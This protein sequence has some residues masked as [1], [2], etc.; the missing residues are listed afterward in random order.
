[1]K[2][3]HNWDHG[4]GDICKKCRRVHKDTRKLKGIQRSEETKKKISISHKGFKCTQK[5]KQK[6]SFARK[7]WLSNHKNS[8]KG[9]I[10]SEETKR[11]ISKGL[12][13]SHKENPRQV[14]QETKQKMSKIRK[15][16][17]KTHKNPMKGKHHT[18]E[19]KKKISETK[20]KKSYK[21]TEEAKYKISKA[22][23]GKKRSLEMRKKESVGMKKVWQN[24]ERRILTSSHNH[25]N[26]MGGISKKS[27]YSSYFRYIRYLIK[28]RDNFQCQLC[29]VGEEK[30][31]YEL[32]V[33]HIDFNKKNNSEDNLLTLCRSCNSKVNLNRERW[34]KNLKLH[35]NI[36]VSNQIF[37]SISVEVKM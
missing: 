14:S 2:K 21:H 34:T 6:M 25:W 22:R 20:R 13:K 5:T 3:G 19:T 9:R 7:K 17:L 26:W 15:N 32:C 29:G 35:P 8:L 23:L 36:L 33:H 37:H 30:L 11:K 31:P 27:S 28:L 12:K 18:K 24:P 16:W 10:L 1:M 4:K